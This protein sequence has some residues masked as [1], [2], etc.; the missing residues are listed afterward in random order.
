MLPRCLPL[1]Q[2]CQ[3]YYPVSSVERKKHAR[4]CRAGGIFSR[5]FPYPKRRKRKVTPEIYLREE[6]GTHDMT[7]M[8]NRAPETRL[9]SSPGYYS[10]VRTHAAGV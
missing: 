10:Y 8:T 9:K 6:R 4:S 5:G 3:L 1:S 2:D 7:R